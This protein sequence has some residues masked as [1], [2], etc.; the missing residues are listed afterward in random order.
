ME[1]GSSSVEDTAKGFYQLI[2]DDDVITSVPDEN[3]LKLIFNNMCDSRHDDFAMA[4]EIPPSVSTAVILNYFEQN[5]H[6]M[7]RHLKK[8]YRYEMEKAD[9]GKEDNAQ[10]DVFAIC[11][12]PFK[13]TKPR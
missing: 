7:R 13:G 11:N 1:C 2:H 6:R 12:S 4:Q 8:W 5:K 10:R 3:R 9:K